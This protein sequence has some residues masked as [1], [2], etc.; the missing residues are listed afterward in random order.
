MLSSFKANALQE[1]GADSRIKTLV[2]GK[3]DVFRVNSIYGFQTLV[4]FDPA[5][6]ISTIS[7]GNPGIF[8]IIPSGNSLYIK[9]LIN[10]QITNMTV[11]SDLRT[12]QFE[13]TSNTENPDDIMYVVRFLYPEY[14]AGSEKLDDKPMSLY[15][16]IKLDAPV[17]T[18]A[19]T[20]PNFSGM[21]QVPSVSDM[22]GGPAFNTPAPS[23]MPLSIQYNSRGPN[24]LGLPEV[25]VN[26][27]GI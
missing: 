4:E 17:N 14:V 18:Q 21:N 20:A 11:V 10:G 26:K 16:P 8:K 19:L 5:E 15:S 25:N 13:L 22:V 27:N 7:V 6:K 3:N 2:Y 23:E 9:A 1:M 12:Y 24:M